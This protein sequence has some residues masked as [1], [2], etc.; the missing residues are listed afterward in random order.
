MS[1]QSEAPPKPLSP[2][3]EAKIKKLYRQL[4]RSF[5]PD[6]AS[7]DA[8]RAYRT[9]KMTAVNDAYAARSMAERD[10]IK[11]QFEQ[12]KRDE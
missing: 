6:L 12:L 3:T 11:A 5:H 1:W 9:D 10:M 4:A 8:D 2:A 7:D